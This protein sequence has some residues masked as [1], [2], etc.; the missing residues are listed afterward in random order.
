MN[1]FDQPLSTSMSSVP[2]QQQEQQQQQQQHQQQH[3]PMNPELENVRHAYRASLADLTFNSKPIITGLTIKAQEN[4]FA[5]GLIVR[6][7]EQQ[8]RTVSDNGL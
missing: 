7:I 3:Q 8:I 6:E 2:L 4:Q 5:A 1:G